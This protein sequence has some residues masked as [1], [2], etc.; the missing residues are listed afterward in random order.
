[1]GSFPLPSDSCSR[2]SP[3]QLRFVACQVC[4]GAWLWHTVLASPVSGGP[5]AILAA[6]RPIGIMMDV[7]P[8]QLERYGHTAAT[9]RP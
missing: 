5:A 4:H 7:T 2:R 3:M 1:M 9:A 6:A 8:P